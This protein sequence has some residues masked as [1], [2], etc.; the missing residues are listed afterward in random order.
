MPSSRPSRPLPSLLPR[1][2]FVTKPFLF[3]I[4]VVFDARWQ[5]RCCQVMHATKKKKKKTRSSSR[6]DRTD[7]GASRHKQQQRFY[8]HLSMY[9]GAVG[10]VYCTY[11]IH[12]GD[13][14]GRQARV[15][16]LARPRNQQYT[17]RLGSD[18][19]IARYTGNGKRHERRADSLVNHE[20]SSKG[21]NVFEVAF[22]FNFH[23]K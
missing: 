17:T 18:A 5:R 10:E 3:T 16:T 22:Q 1:T 13:P 8:L 4:V 6:L 15:L 19:R 9:Y 21:P 12:Q 2:L 23:S 20:N 11:T 7:R 14:V